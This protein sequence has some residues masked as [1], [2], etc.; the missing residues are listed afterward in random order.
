MKEEKI[1]YMEHEILYNIDHIDAQLQKNGEYK[2][3][4]MGWSFIRDSENDLEIILGNVPIENENVY[5]NLFLD[6]EDVSLAYKKVK[7]SLKSGFYISIIT[8]KKYESIKLIFKSKSVQNYVETI[9][10]IP[11]IEVERYLTTKN[12][13]KVFHSIRLNGLKDT[14]DSIKRKI[15][16]V[17]YNDIKEHKE[18]KFY[19]INIPLKW[20][21]IQRYKPIISVI[22]P[23]TDYSSMQ[24]YINILI[25]SIE[26]QIY[27]NYEV[28]FISN[29]NETI[30][31]NY[32]ETYKIIKSKTYMEKD[33]LIKYALSFCSGDY[34]TIIEQEDV[35]SKNMFAHFI[36]IINQYRDL[37]VLYFD[38][39]RFIKD[40]DFFCP[41]IK[42]DLANNVKISKLVYN[43]SFY[44]I[45]FINKIDRYCESSIDYLLST[46]NS[47]E[48]IGSD[49]IVYHK[50]VVNDSWNIKDRVK[51]VAFY[52]PQFHS[53][54]ENDKW[55]GNGFTE[56][57]NTKRGYPMFKNHYQPR[58]P[59]DLGYY[60]LVNDK[61]I[62][63]KQIRL[64]KDYDIYGFCYYYYWFNGKR[65]LEKPLDR[66]L[67]DKSL[68]AP[69]C[70]CWANENWTRRW[71]GLE[72]EILIEQNHT[73]ETDVQFIRD[74]I[75]ILKDER[76]IK[77]N[78]KPLLIIYR[79]ALFTDIEKTISK[80]KEICRQDGIE[81]L[82]ISFVLSTGVNNSYLTHVGD[83]CIEFPP[84][85]IAVK[86]INDELFFTV[87]GFNGRVSSYRYTANISVEFKPI[88][89]VLYRGCMLQWD[90]TARK[91]KNAHIFHEFSLDDYEKWLYK[92]CEY[93]RYFNNHYDNLVF[94]NAWN[95]WGEGTYLEPDKK[96]GYGYLK[97]TKKII[98]SR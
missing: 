41:I 14:I 20:I 32:N 56:W 63:K 82:H 59:G 90:N 1:G 70:I 67:N 62:Q 69:F 9:V 25:K 48:I 71:D 96:Y 50:R 45:N 28:V 86:D 94:L 60:D 27:K 24:E 46:L 51:L 74:I 30:K 23:V 40:S 57:I 19:E 66:I 93:T 16:N 81:D 65:L 52:L 68:D 61:D 58:I 89:Y 3:R 39:D 49:K 13:K 80:W 26:D 6:R 17:N 8:R 34:V 21:E 76:Y 95:E 18:Y 91:L 79:A 88:D 35:I 54:P 98:N 2:I 5:I 55:W 97:S 43:A 64:A 53:I 92:C 47:Y 4:I 7:G 36:E 87:D 22:I 37:K 84:H 38:E 15:F 72:N 75:P 77:I 44:D 11:N 12:F 83:S 42:G 78:E 29:N 31:I 73:E 33:E 85:N 10:N